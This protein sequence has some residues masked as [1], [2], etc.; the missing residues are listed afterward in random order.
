[1]GVKEVQVLSDRDQEF[2]GD[3]KGVKGL[4]G[5]RSRVEK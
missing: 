1:L 4:K 3:G 5:L 2:K